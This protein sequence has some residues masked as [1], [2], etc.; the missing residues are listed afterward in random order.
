[1][2]N[3]EALSRVCV[4]DCEAEWGV[5]GGADERHTDFFY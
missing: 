5:G 2:L 3:V 4:D 1:M